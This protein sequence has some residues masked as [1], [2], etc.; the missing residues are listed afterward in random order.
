MPR[1]LRDEIGKEV[2]NTHVGIGGHWND[3]N[4]EIFAPMLKM[5]SNTVKTSSQSSMIRIKFD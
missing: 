1:P 3:S 5:M 2:V 4:Y